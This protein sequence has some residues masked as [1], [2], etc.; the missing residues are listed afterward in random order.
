MIVPWWF[1]AQAQR[2]FQEE[3]GMAWTVAQ[4]AQN[5]NTL[6]RLSPP[7]PQPKPSK[8]KPTKRGK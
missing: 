7:I 3:T 4:A 6:G 5:E 1:W 2:L 8:K